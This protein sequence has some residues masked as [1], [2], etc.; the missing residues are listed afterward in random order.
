MT[1]FKTILHRGAGENN[2]RC[3]DHSGRSL[4]FLHPVL[5]AREFI[6]LPVS[7]TNALMAILTSSIADPTALSAFTHHGRCPQLHD[8]SDGPNA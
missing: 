3:L 1:T 8:T 7:G 4:R 5:V 6:I 2:V